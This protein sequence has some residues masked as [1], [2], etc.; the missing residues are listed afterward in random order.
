MRPLYSV[1]EIRSYGRIESLTASGYKCS[2]G[3][4]SGFSV[5][6]LPAFKVG[7]TFRNPSTGEVIDVDADGCEPVY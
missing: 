1:P 6:G 2:P 4:D 5:S 3:T 7:K